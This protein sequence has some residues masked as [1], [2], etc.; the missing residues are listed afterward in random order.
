MKK[1][2][3]YKQAI[4][5]A[6]NDLMKKDKDI[7]I[8]GLGVG[9]PKN[10]FGTTHGLK[11]KY[12]RHRVFDVPCSENALTGIAIGFGI[13]KK[14]ILTHQR[15]DFILLSFDQLINNAAKLHY[16]FGGNLNTNITIRV[17]IGKGWGQGPTHS[18]NLQSLLAHIPGL[19]IFYPFSANDAYNILVKSVKDPNPVL[20]LEHRWLYE[21]SSKI[22]K[23]KKIENVKCLSHGNTATVVC[24]GET[25]L[26]A[27][28]IKK[29]FKE[30]LIKF[31]IFQLISISPL[32]LKLIS[33][34]L[35]KTKKLIILES[36]NKTMSISSEINS[37]MQNLNI[38]FKSL[39]I[40]TPDL[41]TPTS[42]YL[43]K[44]FYPEIKQT[45]KRIQQ[46]LNLKFKFNLKD[47]KFHDIPDRYFTGPF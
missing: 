8:M 27:Y 19:K 28:K 41:P 36:S 7:I 35:K 42:F 2:I 10:I 33:N 1:V 12:G 39:L 13:K 14:V 40:S 34:S 29:I 5:L 20:I 37:R 23:Q 22:Q 3:K 4:N 31:D 38:Q 26:D 47:S 44:K 17:I 24:M 30:K 15:F 9:D 6:L 43:T 32:N 45:I 25:V 46:L 18:Q 11:K 21:L 16:M